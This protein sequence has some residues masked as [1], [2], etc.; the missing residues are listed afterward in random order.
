MPAFLFQNITLQKLPENRGWIITGVRH[1]QVQEVIAN[2]P[3]ETGEAEVMR[4]ATW[5]A[6]NLADKPYVEID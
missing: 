3:T 6:K 4:I 1:N 5:L 2:L